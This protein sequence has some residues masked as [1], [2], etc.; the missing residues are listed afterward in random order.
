MADEFQKSRFNSSA[1]KAL[2][3]AS[4]LF[5]PH[6]HNIEMGVRKR[7]KPVTLSMPKKAALPS[8]KR[9]S[10]AG[11]VTCKNAILRHFS[12]SIF[13]TVSKGC[14]SLALRGSTQEKSPSEISRFGYRKA[15]NDKKVPD[16]VG[17]AAPPADSCS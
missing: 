12:R 3:L 6:D 17:S 1:G 15:S 7:P 4:A 10:N 5:G 9:V 16:P 8:V 11:S 13:G 2:E 14:G